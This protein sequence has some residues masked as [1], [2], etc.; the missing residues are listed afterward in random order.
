MTASLG[1]PAERTASANLTQSNTSNTMR[2]RCVQCLEPAETLYRT[3][4]RESTIKLSQCAVCGNNVDNYCER[5]W[6]LVVIDIVLLREEAYRHVI[7]NRLRDFNVRENYS[8]SLHFVV[9]SSVLNA[10]L[11]WEAHSSSQHPDD[12]ILESSVWFGILILAS[13]LRLFAFGLGIFGTLQWLLFVR[14]QQVADPDMTTHVYLAVLLPTACQVVTILV[15]IWENTATVRLLGSL[16]TLCYQWMAMTVVVASCLQSTTTTTTTI[17]SND[18]WIWSLLPITVGLLVRAGV[19]LVWTFLW[20]GT[21]PLPC[22]GLPWLLPGTT[23]TSV[24][25]P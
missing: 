18:S 2:Y 20:T 1:E 7:F 9:G 4:T 8:K 19:D 14:R 3:Y 11:L 21:A 22:V 24:C 23:S 17:K 16:L 13:C 15:Q 5:E 6:L 25:I 12:P 10:Y